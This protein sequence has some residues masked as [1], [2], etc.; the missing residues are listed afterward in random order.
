MLMLKIDCFWKFLG[1]FFGRTLSCS[2]TLKEKWHDAKMRR[3]GETKDE[4]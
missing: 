3:H 1:L 2:R 4:I